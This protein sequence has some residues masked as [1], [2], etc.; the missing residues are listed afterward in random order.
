MQV[1]ANARLTP[2]GRALLVHRISVERRP[3]ADAARAAGISER[4]ARKWLARHRAEGP[5]GLSDRTSRPHRS[6]TRTPNERQR[7]ILGLRRLRMTAREIAECLGVPDRTVSRVLAR[8]GQG[9]LSVHQPPMH[10]PARIHT[11]RP[12][13]LVHIDVKRL[14]RIERAGHRVHGDRRSRWRG[15]GWEC[16]HVAVDGASRL[17][18]AEVLP[19]ERKR[20]AI[21]FLRRAMAHFAAWGIRVER[22]LTDNGAAYRSRR[23]RDVCRELG[24]RHTRT[25]AYTPRTNGKAERFIGTLTSRWAYG[26]IYGSSLER[27]S[28]LGAWLWHYNHRRPHSG[29]GLQTPAQRLSELLRNNVV[30]HNS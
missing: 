9:R 8:A 19:N 11:A 24:I 4:T 22:I 26:A 13:E 15:A 7:A 10:P 25:R 17:A 2:Q 21:G 28:A 29:I 12:V 5:R 14:G 18:S 1:H 6:P 20:T 27:A 30:A 3:V 23:H 16:V